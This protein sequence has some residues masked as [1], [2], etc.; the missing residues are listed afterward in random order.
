MPSRQ[1]LA[2]QQTELTTKISDRNQRLSQ[3][4]AKA[5]TEDST[6]NLMAQ[7]D[8]IHHQLE[9]SQEV[10]IHLSTKLKSNQQ[11]KEHAQEQQ[12]AIAKQQ[13]EYARWSKLN[14]LIGASDG[15]KYRTFAQGLTFEQL[16]IYSNLQLQSMSDRYQLFHDPKQ[17]LELYVIDAYQAGEIR[18]VKNLS[19]GESFLMSLALALGLSKMTSQHVRVDS[20]F[21]DE[22]FGTLDEETL[23]QALDTLSHIQQ[24]GKLIGVISHMRTLKERINTQIA[25]TPSSGGRSI[26]TGPA[27]R[28]IK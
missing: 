16:I 27:C 3:E 11:A 23:H 20:L 14:E 6:E 25:I 15:K 4:K 2:Q 28:Q 18:S 1:S 9:Q 24:D 5:K 21:L 10:I 8:N 13:M 22:G 12:K 19:G 17:P 7:R 26:I